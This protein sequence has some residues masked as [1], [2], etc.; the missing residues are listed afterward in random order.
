MLIFS[1]CLNWFCC[2]FSPP[3]ATFA[4]FTFLYAPEPVKNDCFEY[5]YAQTSKVLCVTLISRLKWIL[6]E[7]TER[8]YCLHSKDVCLYSWFLVQMIN[9]SVDGEFLVSLAAAFETISLLKYYKHINMVNSLMF[10]VDCFVFRSCTQFKSPKKYNVLFSFVLFCSCAPALFPSLTLNFIGLESLFPFGITSTCMHHTRYISSYRKY[11]L[12]V[13]I[14]FHTLYFWHHTLL[15]V[16]PECC[17]LCMTCLV[18][19]FTIQF[20]AGHFHFYSHINIYTISKY[21]W[22]E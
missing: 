21:K 6:N 9:N 11:A 15:L 20:K 19:V 12:T 16:A 22:C 1:T 10:L 13:V 7:Q 17:A 8:F 3:P 14:D 5:I 2:G 4:L 18:N